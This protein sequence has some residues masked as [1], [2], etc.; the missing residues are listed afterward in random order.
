MALLLVVTSCGKKDEEDAARLSDIKAHLEVL[1]NDEE[2]DLS[3]RV[4][5]EEL[6][7]IAQMMEAEKETD[8]NEENER[9]MESLQST[10]T[11]VVSMFELDE[12]VNELFA[13]G[14]IKESVSTD[15]VTSLLVELETFGQEN[16]KTFIERQTTL[17]KEAI[18]QLEIIEKAEDLVE[19]LFTKEG[20][21]K[22]Q[23]TREEEKNAK[24]AVTEIQN[25]N[26]QETLFNK[27]EEV[28]HSITKAEE[29]A[30]R[31]A[32]EERKRKEA[33]EKKRK[34]EERKA[35]EE[36]RKRQEQ[37]AN[38]QEENKAESTQEE[39]SEKTEESVGIG[40]FAGYYV[41]EDGL[42]CELTASSLYCFMPYSDVIFDSK[43]DKIVSNTGTELTVI[44]HGEEMTWRLLNGGQTLETVE[45]MERLTKE[46]F[47][48]RRT[49]LE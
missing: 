16:I 14:V 30:E 11:L 45:R 22:K 17:L 7:N 20:K 33:E 44:S 23:A 26:I 28:D 46:E 5:R 12:Q 21:V 27:L 32:E 15:Q 24:Q 43:I 48:E 34:E 36:E 13:E 31:K 3:N 37:E 42:L 9:T 2:D 41:A 49:Y 6:D 10:Y 29:E 1:F 38:K 40:K 19:Q 8:F 39:S 18:T 25:K 47:D 35:E 4:N